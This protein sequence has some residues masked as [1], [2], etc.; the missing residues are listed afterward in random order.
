MPCYSEEKHGSTY[1]D[2]SVEELSPCSVITSYS[3]ITHSLRPH[4]LYIST[5]DSSSLEEYVG[6]VNMKV[7]LH[8]LKFEC[9]GRNDKVC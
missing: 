4:K 2:H 3:F 6:D 5:N 8:S 7:Y 1:Q 9:V